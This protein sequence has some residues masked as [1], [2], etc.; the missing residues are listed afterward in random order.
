MGCIVHGVAKSWTRLSNFHFQAKSAFLSPRA[1]DEKLF[2]FFK[3][4]VI[5]E[6]TVLLKFPQGK[7]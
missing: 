2:F 7:S 5:T 6:A 1:T 3:K 4:E